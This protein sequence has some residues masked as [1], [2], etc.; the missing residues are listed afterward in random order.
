MVATEELFSYKILRTELRNYVIKRV[1]APLRKCLV[2]VANR[3]PLLN[4]E[5]TRF[6]NTHTLMTIFDK[7]MEYENNPGRE[8]MFRAAFKLFLM[9]IEH[10][11]YYRDRFNWFLEEVIKAILR[12]DWEERTNGHPD[13][14]NW[15]E[16][17][18]RGGKYSIMR[19]IKYSEDVVMHGR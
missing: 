16:T 13:L 2:L 3:L 1:K 12:G 17:G 5:N 8:E 6:R 9:E 19:H 14:P 15:L 4:R 10:D 11:V 7:F 18:Q